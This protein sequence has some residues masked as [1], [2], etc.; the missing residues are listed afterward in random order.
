MKKMWKLLNGAALGLLVAGGVWASTQ[1]PQQFL[2][3][4]RLI[5]GTQL[6]NALA[7]PLYSTLDNVVAST[8]HSQTGGTQISSTS[9]LV[10]VTTVANSGDAI[11]LPAAYPGDEFK[12]TNQG[13]NPMQVYATGSDNIDGTA[14]ATGVSIT[15]GKAV[16]FFCVSQGQW[17]RLV[18]G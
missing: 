3:G 9:T 18:G 6:N 15:N 8:T 12:V 13:A 1:T 2:P 5:D 11:T 17:N 16:L 10:R 14:G 7:N 4:L